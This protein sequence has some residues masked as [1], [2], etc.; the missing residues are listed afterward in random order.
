M[1]VD[2]QTFRL[3]CGEDDPDILLGEQAGTAGEENGFVVKH[4]FS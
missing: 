4:R 3:V 2:D 1:G